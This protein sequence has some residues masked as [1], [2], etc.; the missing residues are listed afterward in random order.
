MRVV[1]FPPSYIKRLLIADG[2]TE[3]E[4]EEFINNME[5]IETEKLFGD[6]E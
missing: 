2:M 5:F 3:K 6:T 4:A 1:I